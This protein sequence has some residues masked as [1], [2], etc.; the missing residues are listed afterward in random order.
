[1]NLVDIVQTRY[2]TKVFDASKKISAE[3]FEQIKALLRFS[4]S[5]VNSQPWHFIIAH[6]ETGKQRLTKGTQGSFAFNETKILNAS[7]VIIF[8][9]K[10]QIDEGYMAHLLETEDNDGRFSDPA[11]KKTVHAGRNRFINLHRFDLKDAQHWMEKQVYLNIGTVLLGAGTLGI[12]AVPLEGLDMAALDDE[13]DLR[14]QG[15][16]A[17]CGIALGYRSEDDF[18]AKLPKSR[19][20][21]NEIFT[22]LE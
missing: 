22:L 10:T 19:L 4:P 8:C 15:Y 6:T 18:N 2:S 9:A 16:T 1:M 13:F 21:E 17:I 12:D 3:Q 7:H 20:S 5:S 14:S 11:F